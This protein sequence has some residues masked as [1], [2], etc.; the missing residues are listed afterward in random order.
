M[1][2]FP[3]MYVHELTQW[4]DFYWDD[5]RLSPLLAEVKAQLQSLSDE[6]SKVGFDDAH[7]ATLRN[8]TNEVV[9]TSEIEGEH[10]DPDL[11]R[12]SI[13]SKLGLSDGGVSKNARSV[14]GIVSVVLDATQN[15]FDPLDEKRLFGWHSALFPSGFSDL[16]EIIV[17]NW[18]D[19]SKGPM[20][21]VSGRY[22]NKKV[23]FQAPEHIRLPKEMQKFL[24]WFNTTSDTDIILKAGVAHFWFVTIHPFA[25]GNGRIARAIADLVLA[26]A[27][28]RKQRYY[29]MSTRIKLDQK[30]YYEILESS[31][32]GTLDISEWLVWFLNCLKRAMDNAREVLAD[33][34]QKAHV[35]EVLKDYSINDSQRKIMNMLLDKT[36]DGKLSTQKYVKING[37]S[38]DTAA[39]HLNKLVEYGALKKVGLGKA[40]RYELPS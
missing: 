33:I 38:L 39:R 8:L 28:G 29:S 11:V 10:L 17:G 34:L 37:G 1:E 27:D 26:Q 21:V 15:C 3:Q 4:P 35:W 6:L 7:E 12:S 36:F 5:Q 20:E 18:R 19:D 16:A 13:A 24:E 23:H 31:Q 32:K 30:A 14:E 2:N 22:G 25:D 9:K 40:T